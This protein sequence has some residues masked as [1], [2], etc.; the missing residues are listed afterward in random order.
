[1]VAGRKAIHLIT[2]VMMVLSM[3]GTSVNFVSAAPNV[4]WV[5]D[6]WDFGSVYFQSNSA[7]KTFEL[8]NTG[9]T[10]LTIN[11][12]ASTTTVTGSGV[13]NI[14]QNNCLAATSL[15]PGQSCTVAVQFVPN[16][17][18]QTTGTL[19]VDVAG[20][21]IVTAPLEGVGVSTQLMLSPA[22][23]DFGNQLVG[24]TSSAQT[25]TATNT[26]SGPITISTVQ[27]ASLSLP[28]AIA[29]NGCNNQ[30]L[31]QNQTCQVTVNFTPSS[32]GP[33]A[34]A[35]DF[36]S[37]AP[38]GTQSVSL[39][40]TGVSPVPTLNP[41]SVN[42]GPNTVGVASAPRTVQ[43]RNNTG[44]PVEIVNT[45]VAQT[46]SDFGVNSTTC[47]VNSTVPSGGTCSIDVIFL[48]TAAGPLFDTLAVDVRVNSTTQTI[49]SSLFGVGTVST[50]TIS[51]SEPQF[52]DSPSRRE[53]R[54]PVGDDHQSGW[55]RR[56]DFG[57]DHRQRFHRWQYEQLPCHRQLCPN[58][59]GEPA[60]GRCLLLRGDSLQPE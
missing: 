25:V 28:F 46:G 40:G 15:N 8:R 2:I 19:Q 7:V 30:T 18:G 31:T 38:P 34:D 3:L 48:P 22:S 43:L 17:T 49:T 42:F 52:R 59:V 20:I 24:A 21:G 36:I 56:H 26:S 4:Q 53:Q 9:T 54:G 11:A 13:F 57:C 60:P 14:S 29:S 35:L 44:F 10:T 47:A 6:T 51:P 58:G 12:D 27:V 41:S 5:P 1:M 16:A 32:V 39:N 33:A 23:L 55:G 50:L 45:P 37:T